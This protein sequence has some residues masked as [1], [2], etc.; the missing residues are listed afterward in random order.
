MSFFAKQNA[1]LLLRKD[2]LQIIT[3]S[4]QPQQLTFPA[5]VVRHQEVI[6]R[7]KFEQLI[8]DFFSKSKLSNIQ[9]VLFLANDVVFQKQLPQTASEEDIQNFFNTIPFSQETIGKKI[10]R[11]KNGISLFA[12]NHDLYNTVVLLAKQQA[13]DLK[14]VIPVAIS[15][16]LTQNNNFSFQLLSKAMS[17]GQLI[18]LVNFLKEEEE[19]KTK[20]IQTNNSSMKQYL[21]LGASLLFLLGTIAVAVINLGL[22]PSHKENQHPTTVAKVTPLKRPAVSLT[23]STSITPLPSQTSSS[24]TVSKAAIKIQIL[25][26]SGI[27]GQANLVKDHL[28]ALGFT[29]IQIGNASSV[30]ATTK[31]TFTKQIPSSYSNS[32]QEELQTLFTN[33]ESQ[34]SASISADY[35]VLVE[36]GEAKE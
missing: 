27:S 8:S 15:P 20:N 29:N 13:I 36:T 35:D 12:T 30:S 11:T 32:I 26:G 18:E 10:I 16:S 3:K 24:E 21:M 7:Q 34:Q 4:Q 1:F 19:K 28:A 22:L 33:V 17:N 2:S 31:I 6:N 25:N 23:P 9:G 14:K 5:E